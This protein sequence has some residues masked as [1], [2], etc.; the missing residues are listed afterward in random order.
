MKRW[1]FILLF[2]L[3]A[4][5]L[6]LAVVM[7][8]IKHT[9]TGEKR[10]TIGTIVNNKIGRQGDNTGLYYYFN[11]QKFWNTVPGGSYKDS[12]RYITVFSVTHPGRS[13]LLTKYRVEEK[14]IAPDSGWV[15]IPSIVIEAN[16]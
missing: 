1:H 10:Y 3:A 5:L 12:T 2:S 14:L 4:G 16:K 8:I 11:G 9:V 7:T 13:N 15:E 6:I